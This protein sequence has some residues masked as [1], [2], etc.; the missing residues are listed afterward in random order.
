[1]AGDGFTRSYFHEV[2]CQRWMGLIAEIIASIIIGGTA[3]F[4]VIH[5]DLNNFEIV[6]ETGLALTWAL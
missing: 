4:G 2:W 3:F 5:K 1:M 6:A